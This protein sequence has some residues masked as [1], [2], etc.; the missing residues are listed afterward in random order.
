MTTLWDAALG[1]LGGRLGEAGLRHSL[2]VAQSAGELAEAYGVD[3]DEARL[4]GLLHDWSKDA[5][6]EELLSA[7][8]DLGIPV[9]EVDLA[10][11]YLLHAPVAAA[12]IRLALPEVSEEVAAAIAAHTYGVVPMQPL[13][14]IVYVADTIEPGRA[15]EGVEALREAVGQ[16]PLVELFTRA[17]ASSLRHLVETR[18]RIHPGTIDMWNRLVSGDAR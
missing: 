6:N 2:G 4:A 14:M 16:V 3:R 1:A 8:V 9:T 17:Y 11:P 7:A 10:V 15:H 18:R 5:S 12:E 13:D